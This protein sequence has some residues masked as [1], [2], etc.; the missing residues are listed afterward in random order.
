M[1]FWNPTREIT[2]DERAL[3]VHIN[4]FGSDGYP[5]NKLA[6]GHGW[7]WGPF[8]SVQGPPV[9]F[10]TKRQAVASF[11]SF[12]RVLATAKREARS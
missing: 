10:E 1:S 9:V 4:R 3:L 5:I 6:N 11:E 2:E 7:T 8:R 12:L